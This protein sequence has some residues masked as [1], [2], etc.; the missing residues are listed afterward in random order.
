MSQDILKQFVSLRNSLELER[1]N[2]NARLKEIEAVL[3]G[4]LL[5]AVP[6]A[7]S[8]SKSE[9]EPKTQARRKKKRVISAEGRAAIVAGTKARWARF[10]AARAAAEKSDSKPAPKAKK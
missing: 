2:L 1:A 10:H 8:A 3:G 5:P 4:K 6:S 9:S 7:R